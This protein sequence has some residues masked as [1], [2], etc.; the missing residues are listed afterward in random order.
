MFRESAVEMILWIDAICINQED[1]TE[2]GHQVQ[3]MGRV[4]SKATRVLVW[5]GEASE[6]KH[7]ETSQPASEILFARLRTIAKGD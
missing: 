7:P 4:C 1:I 3:L 5:L 2:R 6:E